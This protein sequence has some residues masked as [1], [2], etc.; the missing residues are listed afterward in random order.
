MTEKQLKAGGQFYYSN[1]ASVEEDDIRKAKI[2][3]YE[4]K[5]NTWR[6]GFNIYF[7]G[8]LIYRSKTF[9][10]MEKRLKN[11]IEEWHLDKVNS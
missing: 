8:S 11:L 1:E 10:A 2:W 9:K 7:D 6:T 5:M 3:Y 4:D